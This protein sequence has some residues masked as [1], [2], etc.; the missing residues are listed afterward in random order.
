MKLG[1]MKNSEFFERVYFFP[2]KNLILDMHHTR[3]VNIQKMF[4]QQIIIH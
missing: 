1:C 4:Q 3:I 2:H